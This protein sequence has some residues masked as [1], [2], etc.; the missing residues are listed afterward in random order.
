[1]DVA[2]DHVVFEVRDPTASV[3]FYRDVLGLPP[4]RLDEYARGEVPFPS[5]RVNAHTLI[6]LF[7]PKLW[8]GDAPVNPN[9]TCLTVSRADFMALEQRLA[10]AGV[11]IDRRR[12]RNFG[13]QGHG[14]AVY[15]RDPDGIVL[16]VRHYEGEA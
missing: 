9:H 16:E 3:A 15:F 11:A 12:E 10:Q 6:D 7:P 14:T 13:A 4:V 1:M 8:D 2:L 5:V